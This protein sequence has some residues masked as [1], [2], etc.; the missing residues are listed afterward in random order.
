[1]F[2]VHFSQGR[3]GTTR[4]RCVVGIGFFAAP[5]SLSD[6]VRFAAGPA[7]H[8]IS[9]GES[10]VRAE[11]KRGE[12]NNTDQLPKGRFIGL[13]CIWRENKPEARRHFPC[14]CMIHQCRVDS[15]VRPVGKRSSSLRYSPSE[16][17]LP[18]PGN[19]GRVV[20][21]EM[22][23]NYPIV[24]NFRTLGSDRETRVSE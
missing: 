6:R 12:R 8:S 1:M 9:D 10:E 23:S 20:K 3:R 16:P 2:A 22:S 15:V 17:S 14:L 5:L 13:F 4:T 11:K 7:E 19:S 21:S 18:T 24:S